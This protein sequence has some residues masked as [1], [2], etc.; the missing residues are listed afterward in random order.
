[1]NKPMSRLKIVATGKVL[2]VTKMGDLVIE[3]HN[4]D[5]VIVSSRHC[6]VPAERYVGKY[7]TYHAQK[8]VIGEYSEKAI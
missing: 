7:Y 8:D 1:M 3:M 6:S 4:G 2:E 5:R